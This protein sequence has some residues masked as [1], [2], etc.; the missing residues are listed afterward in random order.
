MRRIF[1]QWWFLGAVA[2]V[3]TAGL[4]AGLAGPPLLA[5]SF[6]LLI[7]PK[8]T[9]AAV[10]FLMAFSL[11][12]SRLQDAV[13]RPSAALWGSVVNLGWLP[14]LAAGCARTLAL[15]DFALGTIIS[16]VSPCTLATA[17]VFTRR[18]GGNDAISLLVTLLTN[19][20]CV[21][22]TPVWLQALISQQAHVDTAG[23]VR[24]LLLCVLLPTIVGQV[25]QWP[26]AGRQLAMRYR[27]PI[28]VASQGIVLL[29]I[30]AAAVDAGLGLRRQS[31]WPSAT[32][33]LA[34]LGVCVL[35][36]A[37]GLAAGWYGGALFRMTPADRIAT[38][39]AGSQK[40]LPVGLLIAANPSV[41]TAGMPF[42]TFPLLAYHAVQLLIDTAIADAWRARN[43]TPAPAVREGV[44]NR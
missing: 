8:V 11:D 42:V 22:V 3:L 14:L 30:S 41:V 6:L 1:L 36:H 37:T 16:A 4:T 43:A 40:T 39:I 38:A 21:V 17:S 27:T 32:D 44:E 33:G 26:R 34:M 23:L 10:L 29:I 19:A 35:V 25:C 7:R 15:P 24:Q 2:G 12:S 31:A 20:V 5:E 18:A 13:R 9:T 28:G